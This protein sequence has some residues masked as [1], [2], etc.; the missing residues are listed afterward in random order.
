MEPVRR[1]LRISSGGGIRIS[2]L[3]GGKTGQHWKIGWGLGAHVSRYSKIGREIS[4]ILLFE[5]VC[6]RV[7]RIERPIKKNLTPLLHTLF[8]NTQAE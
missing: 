5:G 7:W 4:N 3:E 2:K 8:I 1:G 6:E